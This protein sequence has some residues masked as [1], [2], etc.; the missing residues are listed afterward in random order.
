[1]ILYHVSLGNKEEFPKLFTPRIPSQDKRMDDEEGTITRICFS[2][3]I[4]K[5]FDAL[6]MSWYSLQEQLL[7]GK[8]VI[9]TV[10]T[11]DTEK[12]AIKPENIITAH[13]LLKNG[14]VRDAYLSNEHWITCQNIEV[15]EEDLTLYKV[16]RLNIATQ[17]LYDW[18]VIELVL[19]NMLREDDFEETLGILEDRLMVDLDFPEIIYGPDLETL[20]IELIG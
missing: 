4:I 7:D 9:F 10:F 12:Y 17:D 15:K 16:N 20:E 8:D 14:Y 6:P 13:D 11:M 5:A 19:E 18:E 2:T 1:M 3:D